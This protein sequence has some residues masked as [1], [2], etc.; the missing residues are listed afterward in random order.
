MRDIYVAKGNL[1]FTFPIQADSPEQAEE[2]GKEKLAELKKYLEFIK[3]EA[4]YQECTINVTET[5][6]LICEDKEEED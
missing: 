3:A 5:D 2:V 1:E 4:N 6:L